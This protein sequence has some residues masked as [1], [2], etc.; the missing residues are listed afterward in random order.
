M[1]LDKLFLVLDYIIQQENINLFINFNT[2]MIYTVYRMYMY[3]VYCV[4]YEL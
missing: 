3:Y 4:T 1:I 2:I